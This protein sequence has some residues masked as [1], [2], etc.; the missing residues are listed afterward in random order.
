[1]ITTCIASSPLAD[2]V[3]C[4]MH[5]LQFVSGMDTAEARM[6]EIAANA[7]Q[8]AVCG[9]VVSSASDPAR[10]LALALLS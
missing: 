3:R 4:Y 9:R 6:Q 1:M 8:N 10:A 2:E 7:Q 5:P